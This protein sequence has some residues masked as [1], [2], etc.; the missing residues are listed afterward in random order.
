ME[1]FISILMLENIKPFDDLLEAPSFMGIEDGKIVALGLGFGAERHHP[2]I[3]ELLNEYRHWHF[4]K[5]DGAVDLTPI[6]TYLNPIFLK[7]GFSVKDEKQIIN[8]V[9][10]YPSEY[11]C[12]EPFQ[13]GRLRLTENTEEPTLVKSP[14]GTDM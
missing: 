8:G 13:T 3:A 12:P 10:I 1:E 9:V 2:S 7:H 5:A 11:L 4:K 6:T 14:T